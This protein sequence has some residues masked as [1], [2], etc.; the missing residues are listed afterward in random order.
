MLRELAGPFGFGIMLFAALMIGTILLSDVL[1]TLQRYDLSWWLILKYLGLSAPQFL[2]LC[3]PMGALLGTLIAVGRLNSDHEIVALRAAG[4][5]LYRVLLPFLIVGTFLAGL[6]ILGNELLVP[7][8]RI[9]L[10][11][12]KN[13]L[14]SGKYGGKREQVTIPIMERGRLR[15]LLTA[16]S[17]QGTQLE[18][19]VL[20]YFD[21]VSR[22]ND[23][24]VKAAEGRW[25]EG[26]WE[27]RDLHLSL[28]SSASG[29]EGLLRGRTEEV[30]MP[31]FAVSPRELEA[32]R[33]T[34]EDISARQLRGVIEDLLADQ[35]RLELDPASLEA[36]HGL[37][38]DIEEDAARAEEK[39]RT[40][41][42]YYENGELEWVL[43]ADELSELPELR[44]VQLFHFDSRVRER[45]YAVY[46][47][48]AVWQGRRG[49]LFY[50]LRR[51]LIDP[52]RED[53]PLVTETQSGRIPEFKLSPE[54]LELRSQ[55]AEEMNA[56]QLRRLIYTMRIGGE[57][58]ERTLRQYLTELHFK[59]S[60][61][62]TPVFFIWIAFPLAIM[63]QRA[64]NT[65]G[66]GIALLIILVYMASIALFR[67]LGTAGVLAP[68]LAA[69]VPN[70]ALAIT[71]WRL[72]QKRQHS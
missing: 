53:E 7:A 47:S 23:S 56:E 65:R 15:W 50:D 68:A 25:E 61:P 34:P 11:Q 46:A 41:L 66:M 2:V 38:M 36:L 9:A 14:R 64:S 19:V 58:D 59:F 24:I 20:F 60:I 57:Y 54:D 51:V 13:D 62:L 37:H 10:V 48:R 40:I 69:W 31:D 39:E 70:L 30:R 6:T 42:P 28:L 72:M 21:P 5:G 63:P 8:S 43:V 44:N 49:W 45:N 52:Q 17:M 67:S 12:L 35:A 16:G 29:G 27:F 3:I 55:T 1:R 71:G 26:R 22:V 33:L 32:K 18:D 4:L